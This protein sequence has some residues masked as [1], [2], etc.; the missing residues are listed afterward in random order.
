MF[1]FQCPYH[2]QDKTPTSSRAFG[3]QIY[4]LEQFGQYYWLKLQLPHGHLQFQQGFAR[5]LA[6]Y[7]QWH[8]LQPDFLLPNQ[9]YTELD[10]L[11]LPPATQGLL[12]PHVPKAYAELSQLS[13]IDVITRIGLALDQLD[14][15]HA[16]GYV[17]GDIKAAHF[18]FM[19]G[20]MFLIDFEQ[21]QPMHV[22]NTTLN[23]TPR[24]M[25]PE[26]FHTQRKTIQTDLY[27]FGIVL[28]EWLTQTRLSSK[29]YLDWA[30]FHCQMAEFDLPEAW[31]ALQPCLSGLLARDFQHRFMSAKQASLC[32][33]TIKLY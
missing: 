3:R 16:L 20:Q 15:L 29:S 7:Q 5:E 8:D 19:A 4:L 31:S 9:Y 32:L 24:Y 11:E 12:L 14:E 22:L 6:C 33:K 30:I 27:A 17:H 10:F 28:Y 26:L 13:F 1:D 18:R 21:T 2:A 23:A 25:A